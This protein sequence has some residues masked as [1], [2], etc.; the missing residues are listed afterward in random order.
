MAIIKVLKVEDSWKCIFNW[1]GVYACNKKLNDGE[2]FFK[3]NYVASLNMNIK[4]VDLYQNECTQVT[5]EYWILFLYFMHDIYT[6]STITWNWKKKKTPMMLW[7]FAFEK[8]TSWKLINN[9]RNTTEKWYEEKIVNL[10]EYVCARKFLQQNIEHS[11]LERT[12]CKVYVV[13]CVCF[14]IYVRLITFVVGMKNKI[15][16]NEINNRWLTLLN[17]IYVR[18]Q[19]FLLNVQLYYRWCSKRTSTWFS[20]HNLSFS[21]FLFFFSYIF[22]SFTNKIR[23]YVTNDVF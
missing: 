7:Q 10:C 17:E 16:S 13:Y 18:I 21:F 19:F 6:F 3:A 9:S 14:G 5:T 1:Y 22:S 2:Q 4:N 8:Y 12:L 15:F 20:F 23:V 11:S